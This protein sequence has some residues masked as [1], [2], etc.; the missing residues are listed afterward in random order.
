MFNIGFLS[1]CAYSICACFHVLEGYHISLDFINGLTSNLLSWDRD[2]PSILGNMFLVF[3]F[4]SNSV[5]D[6]FGPKYTALLE[7]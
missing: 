4:L 1:K 3:H 6:S 5:M 7:R 2:S